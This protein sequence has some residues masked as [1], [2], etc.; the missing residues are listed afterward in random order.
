MSALQPGPFSISEDCNTLVSPKFD[1]KGPMK[2]FAAY[3]FMFAL[4]LFVISPPSIA[5][6]TT[7]QDCNAESY[8]TGVN[9]MQG[10]DCLLSWVDNNQLQ[11][12]V[13]RQVE[14]D[15]QEASLLED[16]MGRPVLTSSYW[17]EL[18]DVDQDGWLDMI[19]FERVGQVNGSFVIFFYDPA[20]KQFNHADPL[21][22][23]TLEQDALGYIVTT[24]RSG[25]GW[26]YQL[27]T[28][29]DHEL[30]FLFEVKPNGLGQSGGKFGEYCDVSLGYKQPL[31]IN[32]IITSGNIPD[33]EAFFATYCNL[34]SD[35]VSS[36]RTEP[37]LE[38]RGETDRVP[39]ETALYCV[40][41]GGTKA[42]TITHT[43]HSMFY[44]YGPVGGEAELELGRP[45]NLVQIRAEI[46]DDDTR[47]G[48]ITFTNGVYEYTVFKKSRLS[49]EGDKSASTDA[50]TGGLVVYKDGDRTAPIFERSC[51]PGRSIDLIFQ[52]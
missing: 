17:P 19:T 33:A 35:L 28:L 38:I 30:T 11:T 5:D 52:S 43:P 29:A 37:L 39:T 2:S 21:F 26:I 20:T 15:F 23:H 36:G 49:A 27:Y 9:Y 25:P 48:E 47:S 8:E 18:V 6:E 41:E 44:A 34:E 4:C 3:A 40:L 24:G 42:V 16:A 31:Q 1:G 46:T 14:E 12:V 10:P 51:I 13:W 7:A 22:G 32:D 45:H 50:F